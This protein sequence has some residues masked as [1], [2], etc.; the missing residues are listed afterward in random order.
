MMCHPRIQNCDERVHQ[1][2]LMKEVC[3]PLSTF[4]SKKELVGAFIHVIKGRFLFIR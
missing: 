3:M 4:R 2:L 1:Q